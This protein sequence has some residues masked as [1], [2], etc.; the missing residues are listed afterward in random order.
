VCF[1]GLSLESGWGWIW[2]WGWALGRVSSIR[3]SPR[4]TVRLR[5]SDSRGSNAEVFVLEIVPKSVAPDRGSSGAGSTKAGAP[6][7]SRLSI[8]S[9]LLLI[10]RSSWPILASNLRWSWCNWG[11]AGQ[12][13]TIGGGLLSE[14]LEVLFEAGHLFLGPAAVTPQV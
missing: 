6:L 11:S 10:W 14:Y 13:G 3:G 8:S 12:K 2:G 9:I 7:I 4:G 5:V 1:V